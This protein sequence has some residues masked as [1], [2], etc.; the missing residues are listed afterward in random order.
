MAGRR[1]QRFT[2]TTVAH[3][4]A[5]LIA[6]QGRA[7]L[8]MTLNPAA[9]GTEQIEEAYWAVGTDW[10]PALESI[11]EYVARRTAEQAAFTDVTLKAE[12]EAWAA[13]SAY[14]RLNRQSRETVR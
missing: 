8:A 12:A 9:Y 11:P 4:R 2:R 7:H 3:E 6:R 13:L 10:N 5:E 14:A 1:G